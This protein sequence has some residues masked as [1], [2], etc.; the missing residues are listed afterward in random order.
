MKI[1]FE[2]KKSS[3]LEVL[4]KGDPSYDEVNEFINYANNFSACASPNKILL[5]DGEKNFIKDIEE[6]WYFE[7]MGNK[8]NAYID[9]YEYLCKFKLYEVEEFRDKGYMRISKSVI[10]NVNKIDFIEMEFSG[11]YRITLKNNKRLILSRKYVRPF[12]TFVEEVL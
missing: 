8:L 7:S 2:V 10:V 12:K 6:V 3:E 4:I 1:L 9:N 11:N 5:R